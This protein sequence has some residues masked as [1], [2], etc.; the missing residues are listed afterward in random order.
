M[1]G[2]HKK[3]TMVDPPGGWRYGFPAPLDENITFR[4][5]LKKHGY[6]EKD[7]ELAENYSRYWNDDG[8]E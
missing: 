6:P 2:T 7:F 3:I 1:V 8:P 5:Q 4:E